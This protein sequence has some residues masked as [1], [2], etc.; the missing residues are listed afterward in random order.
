MSN[1]EKA[2][3]KAIWRNSEPSY[4]CIHIPIDKLN[5]F[6]SHNYLSTE[7]F[8]V[9]W[10]TLIEMRINFTLTTITNRQL[11]P[12]NGPECFKFRIDIVFDNHD[13]DGQIPIRDGLSVLQ[14]GINRDCL[15]DSVLSG[16]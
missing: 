2:C 16:N 10:E 11:G 1:F 3:L 7:K 4:K 6:S 13:H 14:N 9:P 8:D 12:R 15:V 5:N